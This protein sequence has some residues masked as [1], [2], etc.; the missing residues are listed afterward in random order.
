MTTVEID[1]FSGFC[2]GVKKAI[3]TSEELLEKSVN[4]YSLGEMVHCPEEINRLGSKGLKEISLE[5]V[6]SLS[7]ATILIRAHGVTPETKE[8]LDST[9]NVIVDATCSIVKHLQKKVEN[10]SALML[11]NNGQ[12]IIF[13]KRNHPEVIGL[14]GYCTSNYLVVEKPE[15]ASLVD[16]YRPVTVFSQTTSNVADFSSFIYNLNERYADNNLGTENLKVYNT[17]C[18]QMKRRVP[19]LKVFARKHDVIIFVSGASSSNGKY[20]ASVCKAENKNTY[21]ISAAGEIDANWIKGTSSI[22]VTGATSTPAWL[23]EEVANEI[24]IKIASL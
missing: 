2:N 24:K 23:L 20:L 15:E 19:E 10:S 13:G 16:I 17:I 7:G 8:H 11:Q 5:D 6:G 18:G 9:G 1:K 12:I 22:G 4:L 3:S 14:L 21:H